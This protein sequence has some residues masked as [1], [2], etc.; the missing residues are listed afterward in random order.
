[1]GDRWTAWIG[2]VACVALGLL[3]GTGTSM[4]AEAGC[5]VETTGTYTEGVNLRDDK[6]DT[7]GNKK[8]SIGAGGGL[9]TNTAV[10]PVRTEGSTGTFSFDL[11]GNA[12]VTL[13]TL[14]A[15]EDTTN[16]L[17]M[18]SG[19]LVRQTQILGTGGIPSTATDATTTPQVLPTGTKTFT[20]RITCTGTCVQTQKIYGTWR[21]TADATKDDLVCTITLN[22]STSDQASC[23]GV[24]S[25]Y[26]Y[27]YVATTL[28]SGTTPLAGIFVQF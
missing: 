14:I 13:G 11:S 12:R 5:V 8:V 7:A 9:G 1:M 15:G 22:A 18:T 23:A 2:S 19:G 27:W 17:L 6:C 10:A 20:G 24:R 21:S 25:N 16:N 28:T 4:P 26:S 3:A